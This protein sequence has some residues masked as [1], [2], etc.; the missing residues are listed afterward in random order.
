[1]NGIIH[2]CTHPAHLDQ[3]ENGLTERDMVLGIMQ[4]TFQAYCL[5]YCSQIFFASERLKLY[6]P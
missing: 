5:I 2:G 3:L 4:C 1:M 6:R